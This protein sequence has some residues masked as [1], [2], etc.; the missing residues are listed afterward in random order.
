MDP[1]L[2]EYSQ[3]LEQTLGQTT[4]LLASRGDEQ[5]VAL[6]VDVRSMEVVDTD[7]VIRTERV[8]L[9]D[10][11]YEIAT[12]TIY[13]QE[14]VL[15]V[16]EHLVARFT[17]EI[18]Q[19]IAEV[20]RYVGDRHGIEHIGS[21]RPRLALPEIGD[22]WRETLAARLTAERPSNQARR[23]RVLPNHR[24]EDGLALDNE[25]ELRLY[26]AL[27]RLQARFPVEDTIAIAPLPG[28]RL[29]EGHTWTPDVLVMGNG[30]A[31][32]IE[33]DGPRHRDQ[34]RYAADRNRD[35][36]FGRCGIPVVRLPVEDLDD[37]TA[38]DRRLAEELRRHLRRAPTA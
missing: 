14:A 10:W 6:L 1:E 36:Q 24:V 27:K 4:A 31:L 19:R 16:E 23:E 13:R 29:R 33:V 30:R 25:G 32:V 38:L 7:E 17:D 28:V 37:V 18:C 35:L 21:V 8:V 20:L 3:A 22:D 26:R 34:R 9:E 11:E 5:A 2:W 12:R 15:D